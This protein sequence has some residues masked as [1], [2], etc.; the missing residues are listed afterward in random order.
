[1]ALYRPV[2]TTFWHDV[3]VLEEMTPE[4]KLFY[5]Y[6]LT[7]PHTKQ[8]GVYPI[9]KKTMSYEIG[10][11]TESVNSLLERFETYH[12]LVRYNK[13]TRELALINW[14]KYNFP[15]AGTPIENCVKKELTEVKDISLLHLIHPHISNAKIKS[16]YEE[17]LNIDTEPSRTPSREPSRGEKEKEEE[18][19][20]QKEKEEEKKS[21][22]TTENAFVVYEQNFGILK[23]LVIE[24]INYWLNQFNDQHDILIE[25]MKIA[26]KRN[27]TSFGYAESILKDW[28][29]RGAKSLNDALALQNEYKPKVNIGTH[30]KQNGGYTNERTQQNSGITD[31]SEYDN[32]SL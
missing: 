11:S 22:T 2:Q 31:T 20:K 24:D 3:K 21:S 1:M 6:L 28:H 32:L 14:G 9:S 13:E 10:Y 18:K 15:R 29:N 26:V 4:D 23:P 30:T 17:F 8:I 27:K 5:L 7:N 25:A 16:I 12:D 19:E